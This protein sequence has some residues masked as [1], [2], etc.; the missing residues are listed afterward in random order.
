M[1]AVKMEKECGCFKRSDFESVKIFDTKDDALIYAQEMC[2][3]MNETFCKKHRFSVY[4]TAE[5]EMTIQLA[6][7]G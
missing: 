4:E 3:Q 1:I 5:D 6:M 7:N 2:T